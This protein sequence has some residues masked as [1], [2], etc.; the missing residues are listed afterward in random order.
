[1]RMSIHEIEV[2]ENHR[3]HVAEASVVATALARFAETPA[4]TARPL[5]YLPLR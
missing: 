3:D 4:T 2:A 5:V 1:M